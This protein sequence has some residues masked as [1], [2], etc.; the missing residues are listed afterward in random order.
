YD[1]P[2]HIDD[3]HKEIIMEYLEKSKLRKLCQR[4][5]EHDLT[6]H[7][8]LLTTLW[9]ALRVSEA[10]NIRG[11]DIQC[12]ELTVPRI[13]KG[14]ATRQPIHRDEDLLFYEMPI[15]ALAA[16]NPNRLFNF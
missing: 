10:I 6:H 3:A 11:T 1:G 5:Y 9:H 13:K 7:L 14:H 16:E 4:V 12:G 8:F 2:G 15:I